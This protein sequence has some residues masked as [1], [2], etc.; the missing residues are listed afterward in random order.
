[1]NIKLWIRKTLS[2]GLV[3]VIF[4]TY[5]MVT[6]ANPEAIAGE[7]LISGKNVNGQT[8]FVMVN[9]ESVQ[10]G[11][12]I[13]SS[14]TIVTPEDAGAIINLGKIGKLEL[15]PNTTLVL[16]FGKNGISGDLL[17]GRV[18]VLNAADIVNFT[19]VNG[20]TVSLNAGESATATGGKAQTGGSG[21]NAALY[22]AMGIIAASLV[23][24]VFSAV[25]DNSTD[26]STS[27]SPTR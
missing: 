19:T 2:V 10:S 25:D 20:D 26:G 13:F 7:I 17:N 14:S 21:S 12:S 18:T 16:S 9:G 3:A 8:P 15:A 27:F 23:A 4:A 22:A 5:S 1:M 24:I 6:L 11:R